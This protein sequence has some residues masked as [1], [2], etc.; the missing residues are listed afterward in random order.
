MWCMMQSELHV[1]LNWED[2]IVVVWSLMLFRASPEIIQML[3]MYYKFLCDIKKNNIVI[4][5]LRYAI[6]PVA[7]I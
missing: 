2:G 3:E 5:Q 4:F 6:L 1:S 7:V